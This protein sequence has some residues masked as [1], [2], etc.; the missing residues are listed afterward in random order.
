MHKRLALKI[1]KKIIILYKT[2]QNA[3]KLWFCKSNP[4]TWNT[5]LG[6][7]KKMDLITTIEEDATVDNFSEDSDAEIEAN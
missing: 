7:E 5:I 2:R 4:L 6:D 1:L 3:K